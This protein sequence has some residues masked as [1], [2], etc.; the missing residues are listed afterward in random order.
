[1][2]R[3]RAL[4]LAPLLALCLASPALAHKLRVYATHDGSDISGRAFFIGGGGARGVDWVARDSGGAT[5]ATGQ[6]DDSGGF[7][8]ALA[9]AAAGLTVSVNTGDGHMA[10]TTLGGAAEV[11]APAAAVAS[12]TAAIEAAVARQVAP[13]LA[14][15]EEMDAR[16]R[17]TDALSGVFFILGLAGMALWSR[18]R[19]G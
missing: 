14:R 8:F 15:I 17:L 6:T 19:R 7:R 2:T 5:V 11:P 9:T 4:L 10:S 12:D 16:L 13:L 1:M 3:A 18:S